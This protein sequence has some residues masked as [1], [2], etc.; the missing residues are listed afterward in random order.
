MDNNFSYFG[1][2]LWVA[3]LFHGCQVHDGLVDAA[4]VKCHMREE[5]RK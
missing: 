1:F 4:R 2:A 3:I 5:M